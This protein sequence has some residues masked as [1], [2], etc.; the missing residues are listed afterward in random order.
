MPYFHKQPLTE[1]THA[2][3]GRCTLVGYP[4]NVYKIEDRLD[5]SGHAAAFIS[6]HS[7]DSKT[8][9]QAQAL[10]NT[11]ITA[12]N[13]LGIVLGGDSITQGSITLE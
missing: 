5:G 7:L 1:F 3:A 8:T 13:N 4:G 9:S 11:G 2:D 10:V 12:F 6:R